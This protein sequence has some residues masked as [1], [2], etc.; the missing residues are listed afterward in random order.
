VADSLAM[1]VSNFKVPFPPKFRYD[2]EVK[3]RP[4]IPNNVKPWKVFED[5]IEINKFLETVKEFSEMHI[6][7][8]SISKEELVGGKFLSKIAERN[9]VQLPNNH[10]P[11][12]LVPLERIFDRN[13]VSLKGEISEDDAGTI[14]CNIGT[15]SEPKF[16]KLLRSL[17]EEKR[18]EYIGLL[19]EFADVFAWTYEDLKTYD[20]Y[21]IEH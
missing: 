20:T 19:G 21:V 6:D 16:V 12:G 5:D 14:Q 2:V 3:Y 9:I 8:D 17:T 10:I 7:Q 4:S 13:D 1:S 18:Y 11:R 15:E